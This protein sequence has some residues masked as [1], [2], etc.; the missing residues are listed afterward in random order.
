MQSH[1]NRGR[2]IL[3]NGEPLNAVL[4]IGMF[5]LSHRDVSIVS[6]L[7]DSC[8]IEELH[9]VLEAYVED[10]ILCHFMIELFP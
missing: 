7:R 9:V 4:S 8:H 2:V 6:I 1:H 10:A 3:L 5:I